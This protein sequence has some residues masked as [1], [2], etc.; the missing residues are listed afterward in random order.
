LQDTDEQDGECRDDQIANDV[1]DANADLDGI[2]VA[3]GIGVVRTER[4]AVRAA[5][6]GHREQAGDAPEDGVEQDPL[7]GVPPELPH[8][9]PADDLDEEEDDG[10]FGACQGE[11]QEEVRG[12]VLLW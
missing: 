8:G 6:K 4:P 2:L 12:V 3:A 9:L 7:G 5:L 11:D 10:G 1:R